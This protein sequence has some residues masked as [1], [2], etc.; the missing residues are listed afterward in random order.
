MATVANVAGSRGDFTLTV[1]L[2]PRHV[3]TTC[4][5]CGDCAA[6]A[7]TTVAN[8]FNYGLDQLKAAYLPHEMAFPMRYV[9]APQ[10]IGTPE[11]E[12]IK[13]A[14]KY[15]AIDLD[16]QESSF[17]LKAG[18]IV[19]ATGWQ[20]YD[21]GRITPI[22]TTRARTSSPTSRWSAWLPTTAPPRARFCG[23][24]PESRRSGWP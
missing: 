20:P 1:T 4:T 5:A 15:D 12:R 17:E 21:A 10:V 22:T 6:A 14:C 16:E 2:S 23:R 19:W 3:K 13:A 8:P 9:V 11:G 24:R 18:A 7:E